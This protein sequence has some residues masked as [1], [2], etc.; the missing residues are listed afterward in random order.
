M[1]RS[2][3]FTRIGSC[4]SPLPYWSRVLSV[5]T[6]SVGRLSLV[7]PALLRVLVFPALLRVTRPQGHPQAGISSPSMISSSFSTC[8]LHRLLQFE[9]VL[10]KMQPTHSIKSG[11]SILHSP[12]RSCS[13]LTGSKCALQT[14]TFRLLVVLPKL[15]GKISHETS[16]LFRLLF[17]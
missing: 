17:A 4:V 1:G 14:H 5:K 11:S 3:S 16:S 10:R 12:S 15:V 9:L 8:G 7:F 6:A 13:Y 2:P